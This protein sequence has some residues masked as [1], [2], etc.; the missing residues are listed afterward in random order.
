MIINNT[1]IAAELQILRHTALLMTETK[2][3]RGTQTMNTL[4]ERQRHQ[5]YYLKNTS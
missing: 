1:F 3:N 5:G 4:A 2:T